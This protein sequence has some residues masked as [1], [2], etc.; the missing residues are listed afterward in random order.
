M[1]RAAS[2]RSPARASARLGLTLRSVLVAPLAGFKSAF[3]AAERRARVGRH[4]A[5][6]FAPFIVAAFGG[7]SLLVLWLK[8]GGL[9][10][11]RDSAS[12]D[13]RWAY[14]GTV[15][16]LGSLMSLI[17][18]GLWGL[19]GRYSTH[20]MGG[21]VLARDLRTVWGASS[22]PHV[23]ALMFLLPLD[24]LIVGPA[25]FTTDRLTDPLGRAWT[26]LSVALAVSFAVW[27]GWLFVRG[28]EAA[29]DFAGLR[30]L[31]VTMVAALCLAAAVSLPLVLLIVAGGAR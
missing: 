30:A 6:G 5:E 16:V 8:V 20:A 22:F 1:S 26:A 9:L 17:G 18:Q 24:L 12:S 31:G 13:F 3:N 25:T 10:G 7:A 27:S 19:A 29:T 11:L 21:A 14:L 15:L 28:T 2:D 23:F 4:P